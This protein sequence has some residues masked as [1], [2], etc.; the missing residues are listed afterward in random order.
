MARPVPFRQSD[1]A[2]ALKG[3]RTGGMAVGR[4]EIDPDGRIVLVA[5]GERRE[6]ENAF[7]TWKAKRDARS[8]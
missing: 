7:D 5:E 4:V 2:R 6:P 8:A 1:L 3:A